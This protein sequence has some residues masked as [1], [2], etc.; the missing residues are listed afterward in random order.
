MIL[1]LIDSYNL[2]VTSI[3][4][5]LTDRTDYIRIIRKVIYLIVYWKPII[6]FT[7]RLLEYFISSLI[8]C[9]IYRV[10]DIL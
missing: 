8:D 10:K 2:F 4:N 9:K 1:I 3:D 5:K 6:I 7:Y